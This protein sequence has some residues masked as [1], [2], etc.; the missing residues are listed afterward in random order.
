MKVNFNGLRINL[1]QSYNGLIEYSS[2][3]HP[4]D[5]VRIVECDR[6]NDLMGMVGALLSCFVPGDDNIKDLSHYK[7]R[8]ADDG[9][10]LE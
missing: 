6:L 9:E 4:D 10:W 2:K 3:E 5:S 7:L 1:A 8:D